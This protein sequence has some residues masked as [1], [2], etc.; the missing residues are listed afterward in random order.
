MEVIYSEDLGETESG[1]HHTIELGF[2]TWDPTA[3]SIRNRY[4]LP[5]GRFNPHL[6]SEIPLDDLHAL[7]RVALLGLPEILRRN[8]QDNA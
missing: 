6:S 4:D 1:K 5:N 8:R 7:V 3:I 2:S